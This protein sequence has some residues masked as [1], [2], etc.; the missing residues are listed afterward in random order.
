MTI[1]PNIIYCSNCGIV[2]K[3]KAI[4]ELKENSDFPSIEN[5]YWECKVCKEINIVIVEDGD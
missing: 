1:L 4:K 5:K 2:Y 3:S